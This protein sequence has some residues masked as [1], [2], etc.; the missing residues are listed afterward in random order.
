MSKYANGFYQLL[1]PAKYIGKKVP[2]YRSSW[3]HSVM[4]MCDNN[5][6]ILQWANEAMHIP[7]RNPFT[8]KNTIYIPD[9]F[10]VFQDAQGKNHAEMWEVKP[11]RETSLESAGNSK[12][13]QAHAILNMCKWQAARAYCSANG[14]KFRIIT[15]FD[16]FFQGKK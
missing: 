8:N 7:Y 3:E 12:R 10:V 13:N 1:N 4:R 5:P 6:A 11:S 9:F 16:L 14:I 2:H 15:E